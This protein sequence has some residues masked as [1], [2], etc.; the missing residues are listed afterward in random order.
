MCQAKIA[1]ILEKNYVPLDVKF[2]DYELYR[3]KDTVLKSNLFTLMTG[4]NATSFINVKTMAGVKIHSTLL[5]IFQ[6]LKHDRDMA[7]YTT[8]FRKDSNSLDTLNVHQKLSLK[9]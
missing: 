9:R 5:D 4:S 2:D 1:D 8:D 7:V 3:T 6:G